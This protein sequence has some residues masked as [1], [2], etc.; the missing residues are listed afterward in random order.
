MF[1]VCSK[2][3]DQC[4]L[5][6]GRIV[7]VQ[8]RAKII[9]DCKRRDT[10]FLCHKGSIA[11]RT[12]ACRGFFDVYPHVGQLRRIAERLHAVVFVDPPDV[13]LDLSKLPR[14]P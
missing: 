6:V 5:S 10:H 7:S 13:E 8:R 2:K 11:G 14:A 1:E 9:A 4:L 12:I 3:C